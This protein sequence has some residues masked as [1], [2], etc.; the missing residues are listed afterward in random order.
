VWQ[1]PQGQAL[2]QV[3]DTFGA[4]VQTSTHFALVGGPGGSS[5]F[6][7]LTVLEYAW[8]DVQ[9]RYDALGRRIAKD[10]DT[11]HALDLQYIYDGWQVVEE[12]YNTDVVVA[13][14]AYGNGVDEVLQMRQNPATGGDTYWYH[15]DELGTTVALTDATGA[16]AE[17]YVYGPFGTPIFYDGSGQPIGGSGQFSAIGIPYLFTGREYDA[18]SKLYN[19]RL[20]Y[21]DPRAGRF[22]TRDPLGLWG[23]PLNLGNPY[24]Y[25][26]NNP[27][28]YV[29][30]F[31]LEGED[32]G[33]LQDMLQGIKDWL[34][35]NETEKH[36]L[37][38]MDEVDRY[39]K[40]LDPNALLPGV[41]DPYWRGKFA[42]TQEQSKECIGPA[43]RDAAIGAATEGLGTL[44]RAG[45]E[46]VDAFKGAKAGKKAKKAVVPLRKRLPRPPKGMVNPEAHHDLPQEFRD[47]FAALGLDIEDAAY[48]RWVAGG[49]G[50]N[51]Q[52]WSHDF[53]DEWRAF[54][55]RYRKAGKSPTKGQV[56]KFMRRLRDDPRFQ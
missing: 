28:S 8:N 19:Y 17:R 4:T 33:W 34:F 41:N 29:D 39:I 2:Q 15:Q 36:P 9:Y 27:W 13:D 3:L 47:K 32:K 37:H 30:P 42:E 12:R 31:G 14:Y 7:N 49:P 55:E 53:N 26:G 6:D 20:R 22:L 52:K 56:L 46:A 45:D 54:F 11:G 40:L 25:V 5:W 16:V 38:G 35:D 21:L 50:G 1:A 23:D 43:A 10:G 51:H 18:E 44:G 48:G 24:A